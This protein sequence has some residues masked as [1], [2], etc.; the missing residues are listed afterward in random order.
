MTYSGVAAGGGG[1]TSGVTKIAGTTL[2]SGQLQVDFTAI[3][4][5]YSALLLL[6]SARSQMSS[7]DTIALRFNGITAAGYYTVANKII[8]N[9]VTSTTSN[10]DTMIP[11]GTVPG[12]NNTDFVGSFSVWIPNYATTAKQKSIFG[13]GSGLI[14]G[15]TAGWT[16]GHFTGQW[17]YTAA[18]TSIG[19]LT[20]SGNW[21]AATSTFSLYGYA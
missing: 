13:L 8:A 4:T 7:T 19:I 5:T 15:S 21:V 14:G 11:V 3:P 1:G 16:P 9:A 18:I 20:T 2:A 6:G 10:G 17:N 12:S